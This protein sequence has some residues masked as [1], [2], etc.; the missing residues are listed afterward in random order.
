[1]PTQPES[2][3]TH[4][5]GREVIDSRG[6]A[7]CPLCGMEVPAETLAVHRLAEKYVLDR[8]R[9]EHPEWV[10]KSGACAK[11]LAFYEAL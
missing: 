2:R 11:C 7:K 4:R 3:E 6:Y 10:E 9:E 8:I 5:D 1:M